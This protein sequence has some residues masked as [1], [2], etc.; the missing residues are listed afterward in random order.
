M[1]AD[2]VDVGRDMGWGVDRPD[3]DLTAGVRERE[4]G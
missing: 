1:A 2:A 3:D 4:G